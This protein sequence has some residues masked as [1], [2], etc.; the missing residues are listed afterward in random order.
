MQHAHSWIQRELRFG[1]DDAEGLFAGERLL[2][3]L[4]PAQV[5]VAP[6]FCDPFLRDLMRRM[7]RAGR[8]IDKERLIRCQRLL[9]LTQ[10]IAWSVMSVMKW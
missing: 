3:Q 7:G 6:V 10:L 2:A 4:I 5:E 8:E 1:A 9:G